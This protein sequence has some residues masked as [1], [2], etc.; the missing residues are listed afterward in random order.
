M[1]KRQKQA[2]IGV[3]EDISIQQ[4]NENI[5]Q[6]E[7]DWIDLKEKGKEYREKE[8]L[9]YNDIEIGNSTE[10]EKQLRKRII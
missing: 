2:G 6:V 4:I 5:K 3:I 9:D 10:K 8:L 1:E 7:K